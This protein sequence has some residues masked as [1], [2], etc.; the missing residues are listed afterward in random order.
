MNERMKLVRLVN[1]GERPHEALAHKT[2]A[3][4]YQPSAKSS[5]TRISAPEYYSAVK[6]CCV[7]GKESFCYD[8]QQY[9][10]ADVLSDKRIALL[11]LEKK[12]LRPA[13]KRK[14]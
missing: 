9:I 8:G 10:L 1:E 2:P 12:K 6:V 4:V 11:D 5:P 14:I 3:S 13:P 7:Y